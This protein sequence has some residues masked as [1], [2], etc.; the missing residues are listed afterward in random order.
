MPKNYSKPEILRGLIEQLPVYRTP[1]PESLRL[2][3][4]SNGARILP[5]RFPESD[6]GRTVDAVLARFRPRIASAAQEQAEAPALLA[7]LL[8]QTP[9]RRMMLV[10]N[11]GRFRSLALCALLLETS[12]QEGYKDPMEGERLADLVLVLAHRLDPEWYGARVLEDVRSRCFMLIGNARRVASDLWGA[13]EAFRT[14]ESHLRQGTGDRL[15]RARLLFLRACLRRA[16]RRLPEAARLF[17]RAAAVFLA[18]GEAHPAAEAIIGLALAHRYQGEPEEAIRLLRE[19][20]RLVDAG[21]DERLHLYVRYNLIVSLTEAGHSWEAEVLLGRSREFDE[22]PDP[23]ARISLLWLEAKIALGLG[24]LLRAARLLVRARDRY[25]AWGDGYRA[26]LVNLDLAE[27]CAR[28]GRVNA[29]KRLA[30]EVIPIFLSLGVVREA[31][32]ARIVFQQATA[33]ERA[34][35]A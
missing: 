20:D 21:V 13:E 27:V 24:K 8:R 31:L 3:A 29:T 34:K 32:A 28:L 25:V 1:S 23:A 19:A 30:G 9:E 7:E 11:S 16:Q 10:R 12:R 2:E 15:E 22:F 35:Q 18:A 26:A 14:A 33:A 6:Y 4:G 5:W 17:K